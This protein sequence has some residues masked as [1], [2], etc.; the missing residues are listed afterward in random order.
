L[1]VLIVKLSSLGDVVH[2]MPAIQDL[3]RARPEARIDWLVEPGFAPLVARVEGIGEVIPVGL[4]RW[5][6]AWW[7]TQT[8]R[9]FAALRR[10]LGGSGYDAVIDLQG[11][12]KSA[13]L[14]RLAMMA[15]GGH[16]YGLGNRTEGAGWEPAA[17]W[18]VDKPI[19]IEPHIHAMERS[20]VL[21]ATALGYT[22]SGRPRYGLQARPAPSSDST[23]TVA[24]VHGTSRDDK[25]WPHTHWVALGKRV[26]AQGWRIALPQGSEAEQTR[27]ELVAAALQFERA[28]MVQ[29]WTSASLDAQVDRLAA[30]QGVIGV[31]SGLSHIATALNLPHVQI[32][33][34]PTAWRTGPQQAHGHAHQVSVEG[35]GRSLPSVDAVWAAW[36]SVMPEVPVTAARR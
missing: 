30:V 26:L 31:D 7:S 11:L 5:R 8:W 13:L 23:P 6:R 29:V 3:R 2:A 36:L 32:Y 9:E 22:P 28:P 18:L 24:F 33:N 15:P 35:T 14:A 34:F 4:R 27:A 10:R 21:C 20:R 17:R 25:L 1:R 16:R 12:S 19:E